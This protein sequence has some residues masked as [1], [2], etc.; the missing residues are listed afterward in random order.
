[1]NKTAV[2]TGAT[3]GIGKAIAE[4]FLA[5]HYDIAICARSQEDLEVLQKDWKANYPQQEVYIFPADFSNEQDVK[6]FA[7]YAL[8]Q[9]PVIDVLVNN[10]GIFLPGNLLEEEEQQLKTMM[11]INL[12][13]AYYLS[14]ALFPKMKE[15]QSG[16]I[17]NIC[18]VASLQSYGGGTSYSVSKYAL[19]GL[20]DNMRTACKPYGIKVTAICPGPT[21][22]HSWAGSGVDE[23]KLMKAEDVA[24]IVWQT[25]QLSIQAC[26]DK[27]VLNPM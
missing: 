23:S 5:A 11:D 21:M 12:M 6:D 20:S 19:L 25:S 13:S 24:D 10:A 7:A 27:I 9:L 22:S 2:I 8:Q 15:Q 26:V 17:I 1:M 3:K 14:R 16:H 18:S 4:R